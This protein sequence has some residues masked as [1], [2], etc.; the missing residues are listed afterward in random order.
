MRCTP[1]KC[2]GSGHHLPDEC[3]KLPQNA[4]KLKEWEDEK[5]STGRWRNWEGRGRGRGRGGNSNS[6]H[7]MRT[8]GNFHSHDPN[9][10]CFVEA[11][12]HL[13]LE[14]RE[15]TY[16]V[17]LDGNYSCSNS[18]QHSASHLSNS[19]KVAMIDTSASHYMMKDES[20]FVKGSIVNN[21]DRTAVLRLAGGDA[22]LP[23]KGFGEYVEVNS[24][25]ER[26]VFKDVL[27]VP[28]LTHNLLAGGR[29]TRLGVTTELL[30][31]PH[32][33]L[34]DKKKELFL[35]LFVRVGSLMFVN[36]NPVSQPNPHQASSSFQYN[37]EKLI[38]LVRLKLHYA[39]GHPGKDYCLRMW[40]LGM[41]GK[42]VPEGTKAIDFDVI[43]KC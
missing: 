39:L 33:R 25:G 36:L 31:E 3:F 2:D 29:L 14:D 21:T 41:L 26:I 22:T 4:H 17:E 24:H 27:Y 10:D 11:L 7:A 23:I 28:E 37:K 8:Y 12:S 15:V 30:K 42:K 16:N 13:T 1:K 9:P 6:T 35:G 18:L 5:K 43:N 34:V 20:L 32:F 40:R 38:K 19:C